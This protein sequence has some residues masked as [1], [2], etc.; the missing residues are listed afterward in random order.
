MLMLCTSADRHQFNINIG[1]YDRDLPVG[2]A[3][4][5]LFGS[6]SFSPILP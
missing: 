5:D 3:L 1:K 2:S 4:L 6:G